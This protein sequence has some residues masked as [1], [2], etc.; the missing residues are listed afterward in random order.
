ME[1]YTE[2]QSLG[3]TD[4]EKLFVET[5]KALLAEG[6]IL[7]RVREAKTV[8]VRLQSSSE[9]NDPLE[10]DGQKQRVQVKQEPETASSPP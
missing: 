10:E 1:K 8:N 7:R 2:L 4:E 3:E 9:G 5:G 6:V